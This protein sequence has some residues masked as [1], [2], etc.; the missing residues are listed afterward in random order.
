M[1]RQKT[2][3]N[4]RLRYSRQHHRH[5]RTH[6]PRRR[7]ADERPRQQKRVEEEAAVA[8]DVVHVEDVGVGG[9]LDDGAGDHGGVDL[10][11]LHADGEGDLAAE[12]EGEEGYAEEGDGTGHV[13]GGRYVV[14]EW[15]RC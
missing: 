8:G 12:R 10:G 15:W 2:Q 3:K 9:E 4:Q 1:I 5:R 6:V 13:E 14:L 11:H 7:R